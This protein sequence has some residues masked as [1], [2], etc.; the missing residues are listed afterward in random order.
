MTALRS[1]PAGVEIE[2]DGRRPAGRAWV[3][4]EPPLSCGVTLPRHPADERVS[5]RCQ[6]V[7]AGDRGDALRRFASCRPS[8]ASPPT[9]ATP[10]GQ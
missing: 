9:N 10:D 2:L 6:H 7:L 3:I 8:V 5:G 1:M 4:V